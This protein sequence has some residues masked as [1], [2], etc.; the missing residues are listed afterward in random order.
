MTIISREEI[1]KDLEKRLKKPLIIEIKTS[2]DLS[3]NIAK[4][5]IIRE[6]LGYNEQLMTHGS[7][8][9]F[10]KHSAN[11]KPNEVYVILYHWVELK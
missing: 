2:S 6:K 7:Y 4:S 5:T 11:G 1:E 8:R 9:A 3:D 10:I